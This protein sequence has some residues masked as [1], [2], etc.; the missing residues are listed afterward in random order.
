MDYF[1]ILLATIIKSFPSICLLLFTFKDDLRFSYKINFI[2][3]TLLIFLSSIAS[4]IVVKLG[5]I[6]GIFESFYALFMLFVLIIIMVVFLKNT[7]K[8]L[9]K[10][11]F[12]IFLYKSLADSIILT[13]RLFS[14]YHTFLLNT[15]IDPVSSYFLVSNG[16]PAVMFDT[17]FILI[18]VPFILYLVK[19]YIRPL[20]ESQENYNFWR[21][22]W[23]I[24][25]TF[26]ILFRFFIYP[27]YFVQTYDSYNIMLLI[28]PIWVI[29][30]AF[31]YL[32]IL[33]MLLQT[34]NAL[35]V[36][37]ELELTN[38]HIK[39]EEEHYE[40]FQ[41]S[42]EKMRKTKHDSRHRIL[43][44]KSYI[45]DNNLVALDKELDCE[46]NEMQDN[47][48]QSICDNYAIDV[49]AGHYLA[50]FNKDKI[51][52]EF[53]LN[54]KNN[55][56]VTPIDLSVL[57]GNLLENA[58]EAIERQIDLPKFV[59]IKARLTSDSTMVLSIRNSY[60]GIIQ[61]G[62]QGFNS[63][64]RPEIGI[65]LKSVQAIVKKYNGNIKIDYRNS[66]FSV[67][68]M[69]ARQKNDN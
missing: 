2:I 58:Y 18:S 11:I 14:R 69:L 1:I 6:N 34:A 20:I 26:F 25:L 61:E 9:F 19:E 24:P 68:V 60:E 57:F 30:I 51:S 28:S 22:L 66:V 16:L 3:I 7:K 33:K 12:T 23:L 59:Q 48:Y 38:L 62:P 36:Q 8:N 40:N 63:S 32:L 65:G 56:F 5:L 43:L 29:C 67:C 39:M 41:L 13:A 64:K 52:N 17:L 46:F 54:I 27:S 44:L 50:K 49:I 10:I 31:V 35:Q 37:K 45:K 42:V 53:N 21:Y 15:D 55:I 4:N 47:C